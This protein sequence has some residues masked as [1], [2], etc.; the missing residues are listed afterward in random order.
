V[1][2]S[3]Q[4]NALMAQQNAQFAL[5]QQQQ[6]MGY[7]PTMG[8]S[9]YPPSFNYGYAPSRIGSSFGA[10]AAGIPNAA[11]TGVG[12]AGAGLGIASMFSSSAGLGLAAA[13]TDVTGISAGL[14]AGGAAAGAFGGMGTAAGLG[15]GLGVGG[16][17]MAGVG[18]AYLT[19]GTAAARFAE[20]AREQ[21]AIR[22]MYASETFANPLAASGRGFSGGQLMRIGQATRAIDASSPFVSSQD[23]MAVG[24]MFREM[25]VTRGIQNVDVISAKLKEFGKT[26][27][28]VAKQLGTSIQDVRGTL[29]QNRRA[30]FFTAQEVSRNVT[31]MR[32]AEGMGMGQETF[33]GMQLGAV[34]TTRGMGLTG[35]AGANTSR[36]IA[37]SLLSGMQG[38]GPGRLTAEELMDL[39]NTS[40]AQEAIAAIAGQQTARTAQILGNQ[41]IG[42]VLLAGAGTVKGGKFTGGIDTGL[43]EQVA[44]GEMSLLDLQNLA[45]QKTGTQAG[46]LS[47]AARQKQLQ[48]SALE[49]GLANEALVGIAR[50]I[51]KDEYAGNEDALTLVMERLG[52][53]QEQEQEIF[54]KLYEDRATNRQALRTR[55]LREME[56]Q[57][58]QAD[59]AQNYTLRGQYRKIAGGLSDTVFEPLSVA[60]AQLQTNFTSNLENL[61]A[62]LFGFRPITV[63]DQART[64]ASLEFAT[65]T[66][67]PQSPEIAQANRN[68]MLM[69]M[70]ATGN[71]GT[72][73]ELLVGDATG[74]AELDALA[75]ELAANPAIARNLEQSKE[76][77][78][79][80]TGAGDAVRFAVE[81]A[82]INKGGRFS[83]NVSL[84]LEQN[85]VVTAT[86]ESQRATAYVLSKLGEQGGVL[87]SQGLDLQTSAG[88]TSQAASE[89]TAMTKLATI[90]TS[91]NFAGLFGEEPAMAKLINK[92]VGKELLSKLTSEKELR[93]FDEILQRT[94]DDATA[95]NE[96]KTSFNLGD[97]TSDDVANARLILDSKTGMNAAERLA[98]GEK[99]SPDV[100]TGT[101]A[102]GLSLTAEAAKGFQENVSRNLSDAGFSAELADKGIT[103]LAAAQ[104]AMTGENAA[105]QRTALSA[106]VE[107]A[108]LTNFR[109]EGAAGQ[110]LTA[111]ADFQRR[112][113][114]SNRT[115][116]TKEYFKQ[117]Y[118]PA[119]GGTLEEFES[120]VAGAYGTSLDMSEQQKLAET[121]GVAMFTGGLNANIAQESTPDTKKAELG[122]V[123]TSVEDLNNATKMTLEVA[124]TALDSANKAK[125][126]DGSWVSFSLGGN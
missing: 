39:T 111:A 48:S 1:L 53:A 22:Q 105:A 13:A 106:L 46:G 24:R 100:F 126:S 34:A 28:Q 95:A 90:G 107:Q 4:V 14:S 58:M 30:G 98:A 41:G 45:A 77:R 87:A 70:A 79:G 68:A 89:L 61:E 3:Q 25:E 62:G 2:T 92:G 54:R 120:K 116:G 15:V 38:S 27:E 44:S 114:K 103:G 16:L 97:V 75:K 119:F 47:F 32:V 9:Q 94:Q 110:A 56:T 80:K 66:M 55:I 17:A 93:K 20:G 35:K 10:A 49:S 7:A 82:L 67:M 115:L 121:L 37:L 72:A 96:L 29:E 60:G 42:R 84:G 81:Q 86:P 117:F 64:A 5:M 57:K 73:N 123:V 59:R 33:A 76:S 102:L 124:Q 40:S 26:A 91:L 99:V 69:Q 11:M 43:L 21:R 31:Q 109:G 74:R 83:P 101:R 85:E 122:K 12:V 36:A 65:G 8:A 50:R 71:L 78:Y 118:E 6:M 88:N 112:A 113:L 125:T 19:A 104:A 23:A 108:R 63:T 18:A 52:I 51:V